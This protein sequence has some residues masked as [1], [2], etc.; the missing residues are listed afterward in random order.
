MYYLNKKHVK[1][2]IHRHGLQITDEAIALL[3]AKIDD[4]IH[5]LTRVW[6]GHHKRI[7]GEIINLTNIK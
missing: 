5:R 1:E 7:T 4:Y 3:D 6:N 2:S